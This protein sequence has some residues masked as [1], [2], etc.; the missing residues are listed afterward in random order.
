MQSRSVIW[1]DLRQV[2]LAAQT[3]YLTD[4]AEA[5]AAFKRQPVGYDG[6]PAILI[7]ILSAIEPEIW[8]EASASRLMGFTFEGDESGRLPSELHIGS[9]YDNGPMIATF[10][11]GS[12]HIGHVI[13]EQGQKLEILGAPNTQIDT[14]AFRY[15][16]WKSLNDERLSVAKVVEILK[17]KP[18]GWFYGKANEEAESRDRQLILANPAAF[19][20]GIRAT[21]NTRE[22]LINRGLGDHTYRN[23]R[24][25]L[26]GGVPGSLDAFGFTVLALVLGPKLKDH[27]DFAL[28]E[29]EIAILPPS[30]PMV[31]IMSVWQQSQKTYSQ[32]DGSIKNPLI[33]NVGAELGVIRDPVKVDRRNAE[34]TTALVADLPAPPYPFDVDMAKATRGAEI[35]E[36][37]CSK[38]HDHNVF[39]GI[40]V[41]KVDQNRARGLSRSAR[42]GLVRGLKMA[43]GG[44][45]DAGCQ[46]A[47]EDV[48]LDRSN[49]PGYQAPNLAG[50]W[51]RAPYLHN[52]S[53][54]TL[55]HFL[56]PNQR[57]REFVRGDIRFDQEKVGFQYE[58]GVA[59]GQKVDTKWPGFTNSGHDN[60]ETFFGGIDFERDI[61]ARESLIEYLKTL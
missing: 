47:D 61:A 8:A 56:A 45:N 30:P 35:Y 51:A 20:A 16:L 17:E 10:S 43:C 7:G 50:I 46:V 29:E 48:L 24:D 5:T 58:V 33:R 32:W 31:D 12:C 36:M 26:K 15:Y 22:A 27:S 23:A 38:C 34:L 57:P 19:L 9:R 25:L 4:H 14:T 18:S 53:V 13:G 2:R 37:A 54:P 44:A 59:V 39:V 41:L 52:G 60:I 6:L 11:C 49:A 1:R 55:F 42:L 21:L 40:E 3:K 28:T